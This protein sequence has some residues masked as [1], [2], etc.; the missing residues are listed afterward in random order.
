MDGPFDGNPKTLL[1]LGY[2]KLIF[3]VAD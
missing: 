1:P 2:D 3:K